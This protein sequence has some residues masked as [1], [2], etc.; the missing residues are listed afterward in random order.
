MAF[1]GFRELQKR[2]IS[3][4]QLRIRNGEWTERKLARMT[5][6]SQPHIHNVLKGQRT[7]SSELCD[8]L[9]LTVHMSVAD[10]MRT[11]QG[12]RPEVPL[13][14]GRVGPGHPWPERLS[15]HTVSLPVPALSGLE[16]VVAVR[17]ALDPHMKGDFHD[18]D[19]AFLDQ[20]LP[21]RECPD[22]DSLYLIK[23]GSQ[24]LVRRV[25][26]SGTGLYLITRDSSQPP[27]HVDVPTVLLPQVI[28]AR[29]RLATVV[30][31]W[32]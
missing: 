17:L 2:L 10:L 20:G 14:D 28:R 30:Q 26:R 13:L 19:I 3:N 18:G 6:V 24:G 23:R 1:L 31:E 25:R 4:I 27:E 15:G 7:P 5:G 9:L 8:L 21:A 11:V 16:G 32:S 12:E 22:N 29:V